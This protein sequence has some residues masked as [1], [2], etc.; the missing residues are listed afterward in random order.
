MS[1][2]AFHKVFIAAAFACLSALALWATGHNAAGL[3]TPWARDAALAGMA[4][5]VPY[6]AWTLR[7]L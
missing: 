5:L 4:L 7:R 3:S 1:L 2:A 6:F